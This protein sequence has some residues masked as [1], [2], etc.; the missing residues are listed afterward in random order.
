MMLGKHK[1]APKLSPKKSVEGSIGGILASAILGGVYGYF[2]GPMIE[3]EGVVLIF[4][5]ICGIGSMVSQTGDL[6]AS[7][8]K[9]NYDVKDYGNCIP[10]HGGI[11]DRFDSV[12]FVAPMIYFLSI[13]FIYYL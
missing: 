2:V 12:I 9:R 5:A 1:L 10:G 3:M 8:I 7:G 4:S 11:M 6:V 13:F